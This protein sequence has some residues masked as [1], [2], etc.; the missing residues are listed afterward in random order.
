MGM[1][2]T[3]D[4]NK[5]AARLNQAENLR[6]WMMRKFAADPNF[7]P[8]RIPLAYEDRNASVFGLDGGGVMSDEGFTPRSVPLDMQNWLEILRIKDR[9]RR[10]AQG[11]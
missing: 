7:N 6:S 4:D 11:R 9:Q 5:D 2:D 3:Y 1:L 8:G 10:R